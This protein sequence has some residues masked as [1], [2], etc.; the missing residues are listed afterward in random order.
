MTNLSTLISNFYIIKNNIMSIEQYNKLLLLYKNIKSH[1]DV[2]VNQVEWEKLYK[3]N[4][5]SLPQSPPLKTQ[6]LKTIQNMLNVKY[7]DLI[8]K[9]YNFL[10]TSK[11][12]QNMSVDSINTLK[13]MIFIFSKKNTKFTI[14]TNVWN[15]IRDKCLIG[16]QK[17][18]MPRNPTQI[19]EII[20]QIN[21]ILLLN[22]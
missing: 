12:L 15:S 18:K 2:Y 4:Q 3:L 9:Y 21:N 5:K 19:S 11:S 8:L 13:F 17:T 6:I 22:Q 14:D 1:S 10:D 16:K 7:L 20:N